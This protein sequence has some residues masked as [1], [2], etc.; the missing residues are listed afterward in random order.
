MKKIE[1]LSIEEEEACKIYYLMGATNTEVRMATGL[2][3]ERQTYWLVHCGGEDKIKEWKIKDEWEEKKKI[4]MAKRKFLDPQEHREAEAVLKRHPLTKKDYC[5]KVD[6]S[7]E[8]DGQV[9]INVVS[10]A[11]SAALPIPAKALSDS[12]VKGD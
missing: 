1:P 5:D 9:Q 12:D 10:Y 4:Y 8:V 6:Q 2:T 11:D 3:E 7:I